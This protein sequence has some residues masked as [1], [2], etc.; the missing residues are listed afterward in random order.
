GEK[1][2]AMVATE[3]VKILAEWDEEKE[4]AGKKVW[5]PGLRG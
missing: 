3:A 4:K 5:F 1:E 2:A